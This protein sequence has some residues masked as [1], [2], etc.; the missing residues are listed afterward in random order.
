MAAPTEPEKT[1][2]PVKPTEQRL[3]FH[4]PLDWFE[5]LREEMSRLWGQR[6]L[7]PRPALRRLAVFG[8]GM[9]APRV[10]VYEKDGQ[11][12]IKA[13][14]PGVNKKDIK[15]EM[16]KGDLIIDGERK[17]EGEVKEGEY[18]RMERAH[19]SFHRRLPIPFEVNADQI[20]ATYKDGVLEIQIPMPATKA[21]E[22]KKI[23]V[24]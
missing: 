8:E 23:A 2:V 14:L 7:M 12:M 6:P 17:T 24:S 4:D 13:E 9:W 18:Y 20:R 1:N 11:L 10:D 5:D 3:G 15:V 19:G 22:P 21:L 16:D